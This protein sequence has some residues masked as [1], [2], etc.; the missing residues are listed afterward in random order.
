MNAGFL[1]TK[2]AGAVT[3]H[4][5]TGMTFN[6]LQGSSC[7]GILLPDSP[8]GPSR[9]IPRRLPSIR[10][11][12]LS[13]PDSSYTLFQWPSDSGHVCVHNYLKEAL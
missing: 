10:H 3:G 11:A 7:N 1:K 6:R 9:F 4:P 13:R 8:E 5:H 2:T 12:R